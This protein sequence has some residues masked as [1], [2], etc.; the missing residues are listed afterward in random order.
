MEGEMPT[1]TIRIDDAMRD[2]IMEAAQERGMTASNFVRESLEEI[3]GMEERVKKEREV[4][5][6][7]ELTPLERHILVLMHR[8]ILAARG[9][10][11]DEYYDASDEMKSIEVLQNGFISEYAGQEF[12]GIFD[13]M[14]QSE[15]EMVWDILDMFRILKFSVKNL[16]SDGWQQLG[17]HDAERYGSFQG[18]DGNDARESRMLSYLE[19]LIKDDRWGEQKEFV[20]GRTGE[21]G[22]SHAP[23]LSTYRKM[24]REFKPL[25]KKT[26]R[27]MGRHLTAGQIRAVLIAGGAQE[28]DPS[29]TGA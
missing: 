4:E 18:F 19:Y 26:M 13:P 24:L 27:G 23:M 14:P 12:P 2:Q 16:G 17:L 29:E 9:D 1:L 21:Q 20:L 7:Y 25:W 5:S 15:G 6:A 11:A 28:A 3:F 8:S 10:L 22:N